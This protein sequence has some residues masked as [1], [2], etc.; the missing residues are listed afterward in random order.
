MRYSNIENAICK[1][2]LLILRSFESDTFID[3][4]TENMYLIV[5][6]E[7]R[8]SHSGHAKDKKICSLNKF[9]S[10]WLPTLVHVSNMK[11]ENSSARC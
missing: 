6:S 3:I 11:E 10:P 9:F 8:R 4:F 7:E 1:E 2:K 5:Y